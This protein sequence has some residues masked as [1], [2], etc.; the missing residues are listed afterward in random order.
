LRIV[1]FHKGEIAKGIEFQEMQF[2][3]FKENDDIYGIVDALST[4]K[5]IYGMAG[6]WKL[7]RH[8]REQGIERLKRGSASPYFKMRLLANSPWDLIW[9]GNYATVEL[10]HKEAIDYVTRLWQLKN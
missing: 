7:A 4:F 10:I 3:Y 6:D 5:D 9:S 8:F 1:Y 2:R